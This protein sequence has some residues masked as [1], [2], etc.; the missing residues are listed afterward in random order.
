MENINF[1]SNYIKLLRRF[2]YSSHTMKNYSNN[3]KNFSKWLKVPIERATKAEVL[4]YIDF[5]LS[6]GL[7]PTTVNSYLNSLR[8]FYHY[9]RHEEGINTPNPVKAGYALRLPS[10]LPRFLLNE[11]IAILFDEIKNCRDE[12]M[13]RL[14]LRCGLRVEEVAHL[15]LGAIDL[16]RRRITVKCGKWCRDRIVFM[17]DDAFNALS[18]YLDSRSRTRVKRVFLVEKGTFK[19]KPL[20]VRGIQKRIEYYAKKTGVQVSCHRL[21][22]TMA[23]QLLNADAEAVT[24]QDLLGHNCLASTQRYCKVSNPKVRRDYFKAMELVL[25]QT[26]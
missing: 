15:T 8:G 19:D 10:P 5:L 23:T 22:H 3:L 2:N 25:Q 11:D 18:A 1:V 17:S 12:A 20:S 6:R 14:M 4:K 21:R 7:K 13:F 24:I 26:S 9:L 16:Q